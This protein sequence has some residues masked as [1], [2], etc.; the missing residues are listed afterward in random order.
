MIP[1]DFSQYECVNVNKHKRTQRK[2]I[3]WENENRHGKRER[4]EVNV[5]VTWGNIPQT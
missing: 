4:E 2:E 3:K 1:I 5:Q